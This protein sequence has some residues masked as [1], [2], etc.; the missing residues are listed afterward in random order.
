MGRMKVLIACEES[1]TVCKEFRKKGHD[2]YSCDIQDCSG[3]YPEWHIQ[4]DAIE[5]AYNNHWDLMIGHPP[6]TYLSYAGIRWFNV[7]R[8]GEK[9]KERHAKKDDAIKF[10]LKLYNAPINKI[11][12]E[13]PRG[14][15]Q[16][17][18]PYSQAIQPYYFGDS[19]SK[20]T[21]LWLKNLPF[22]L[23]SETKTLFEEK[24]HVWKGEMG[25]NGGVWMNTSKVIGLPK[26]ERSKIRS[27]TFL[28]IAKAMAEQWG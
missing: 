15:I 4:G 20:K 24:T 28:G 6:C 11:C 5:V 1:Q 26:E 21:L 13:N 17:V 19:F 8:Y 10:F 3:G 14:F 18:I 25:N 7:D 12:L 23:H 9:A 22:L 2:A 27:K 16:K